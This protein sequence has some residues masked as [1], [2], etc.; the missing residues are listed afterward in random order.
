MEE[1]NLESLKRIG[2]ICLSVHLNGPENFQE[3]MRCRRPTHNDL[4]KD[5]ELYKVLSRNLPYLWN[6]DRITGKKLP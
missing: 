3:T 5:T 6:Q 2:E 1:P 4:S